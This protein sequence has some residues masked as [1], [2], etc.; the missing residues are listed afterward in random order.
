MKVTKSSARFYKKKEENKKKM[1]SWIPLLSESYCFFIFKNQM[2]IVVIFSARPE[3]W[4]Q[5]ETSCQ[6]A[7]AGQ[8]GFTGTQVR[9]KTFFYHFSH[10]YSDKHKICIAILSQKNNKV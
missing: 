4:D 9:T 7:Q 5:W 10:F 3:Y 2:V 6:V 1:T 8:H